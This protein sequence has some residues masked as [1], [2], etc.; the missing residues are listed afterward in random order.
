VQR[1]KIVVIERKNF[2]I[3][4]AKKL[5][6]LPRAVIVSTETH[7]VQLSYDHRAKCR[8]Q[9]PC[10]SERAILRAFYVHFHKIDA[11]DRVH[12]APIVDSDDLHVEARPRVLAAE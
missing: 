2:I 3:C 11:R 5:N 9:I 1:K 10:P 8:E 4:T 7:S 12:L 6:N